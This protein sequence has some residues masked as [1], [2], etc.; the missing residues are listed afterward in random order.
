MQGLLHLLRRCGPQNQASR[1]FIVGAGQA[2]I[3]NG[4]CLKQLLAK[5]ETHCGRLSGD[6]I[7]GEDSGPANSCLLW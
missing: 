7:D 4:G 5:R 6:G 1:E 2:E 3:T